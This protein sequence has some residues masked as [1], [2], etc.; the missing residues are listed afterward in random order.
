MPGGRQAGAA[1]REERRRARCWLLARAKISTIFW[2]QRKSNRRT[3]RRL[4]RQKS[5]RNAGRADKN[6][7]LNKALWES[8][9]KS[10]LMPSLALVSGSSKTIDLREEPPLL[11]V[12]ENH[13]PFLFGRNTNFLSVR[14][15]T[16]QFCQAFEPDE[17]IVHS[18]PVFFRQFSP[19]I[20]FFLLGDVSCPAFEFIYMLFSFP[21]ILLF[22]S[23]P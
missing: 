17:K 15:R 22:L 23:W 7:I 16:Y 5:R 8:V 11:D 9:S 1:A 12:N 2:R 13:S 6:E 21:F 18:I 3:Q 4:Q 20:F 10:N 19:A 14:Q